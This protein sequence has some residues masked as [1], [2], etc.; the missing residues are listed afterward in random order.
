MNDY[1][2]WDVFISHAS[3][4]KESFVRP[5]AIALSSLGASVWYDEFSLRLGDSLARSIDKGIANS[6]FGIVVLSPAFLAKPWPEYELR[7]LVAREIEED[8]VILPV[9]HGVTRSQVLAFSPS[10]AD[11]VA[12][13]TTGLSAEDVA[14]GLLR[15]ARPDIY[16][17]H[18]RAELER[19]ASGQALRELQEEIERARDELDV[20]REELSQYRC[21][22]CGAELTSRIDAPM[23]LEENDW[24]IRENFACGYQTFAG[25][26]ERPCPKD[27][28][29]PSLEEYDLQVREMDSK[30]RH[31][32]WQCYAQPKT[33]M[34]RRLHLPT[35]Y[36]RTREEAEKYVRGAYERY[37]RGAVCHQHKWGK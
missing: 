19:I 37:S 33:D 1:K 28:C 4:D 36:C 20:T 26:T 7:G 12:L 2:T 35:G 11:K 24:G 27:P 9:W 23:D 10:L 8:R 29:F 32:R 13:E 3:E 22:F 15:E 18:P 34:A 21:S 17:R 5:L 6:R 31:W 14:I 30:E 25:F 16:V